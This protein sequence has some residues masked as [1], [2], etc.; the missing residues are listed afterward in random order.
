MGLAQGFLAGIGFAVAGVASPLFMTP[1][2]LWLF[3]QNQTGW[4]IFLALWG[5]GDEAAKNIVQMDA[6]YEALPTNLAQELD[7]LIIQRTWLFSDE[8]GMTYAVI[9]AAKLCSFRGNL[10]KIA[11]TNKVFLNN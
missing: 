6:P 5:V 3:Q 10:Q 8:S 9:F 4:A 2:A 11:R 1:A 7:V